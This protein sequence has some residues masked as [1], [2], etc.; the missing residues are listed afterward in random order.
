M[1]EK[2]LWLIVCI[3]AMMYAI[4]NIKFPTEKS[5]LDHR[6]KANRIRLATIVCFALVGVYILIC[7]MADKVDLDGFDI[8]EIPVLGSI[9]LIFL[10][11]IAIAKKVKS[12]R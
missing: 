9:I 3:L 8:S 2:Y 12:I 6:V 4:M 1:I 5:I 11:V 10:F 7:S